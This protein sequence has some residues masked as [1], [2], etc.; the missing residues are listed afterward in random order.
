MTQRRIHMN[1]AAAR[2]DV[3]G[4]QRAATRRMSGLPAG[5]D[6]RPAG[7]N[8]AGEDASARFA[9]QMAWAR[10]GA[11]TCTSRLSLSG[12]GAFEYRVAVPMRV[13]LAISG[14]LIAWVSPSALLV[15]SPRSS[16]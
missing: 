5:A 8:D 15:R 11:I 9:V 1:V 7:V 10:C 12:K 13:S 16:A 4:C 3:R 6:G 2:R 14:T